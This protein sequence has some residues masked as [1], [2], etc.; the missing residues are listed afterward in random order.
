MSTVTQLHP[1]PA[2]HT[3]VD[4]LNHNLANALDLKLQVKQAHWNVKGENFIALHELF[5][6]ISGAVEEYADLLA[7]RVVQLGSTAH[8]TWQAIQESSTLSPYP[9]DMQPSQMHV[10]A[11]SQA[12]RV[13]A[14]QTRHLIDQADEMD[15]KVTADLCTEITRGVDKWRWFVESHHQA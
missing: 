11:L 7:E 8:G 9:L 13:F 1:A 3:L 10:A 2:S 4:L 6:Q 5:D 12:L 15:D 14:D